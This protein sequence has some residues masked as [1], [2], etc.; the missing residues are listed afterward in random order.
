MFRDLSTVPREL[1]PLSTLKQETGRPTGNKTIA[2]SAA[3]A[4]IIDNLL[5]NYP[6]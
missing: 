4:V 3:A 2:Y 5:V 6:R 1:T